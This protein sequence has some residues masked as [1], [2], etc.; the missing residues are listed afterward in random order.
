MIKDEWGKSYSCTHK[1]RL[2]CRPSWMNYTV[3]FFSVQYL[4]WS[5][6]LCLCVLLKWAVLK[7][8]VL[9]LLD[10]ARHIHF[11]YHFIILSFLH[12]SSKRIYFQEASHCSMNILR[13]FSNNSNLSFGLIGAFQYKVDFIFG[14][15]APGASSIFIWGDR[16]SGSTS[17]NFKHMRHGPNLTHYHWNPSALSWRALH[18]KRYWWQ[19]LYTRG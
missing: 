18:V 6:W 17:F 8:L 7:R 10:F 4:I 9:R 13:I 15:T 2:I 14:N 1:R 19:L 3:S 16:S 12:S 11:A 5:F